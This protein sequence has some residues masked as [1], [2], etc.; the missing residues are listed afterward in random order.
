VIFPL[1]AKRVNPFLSRVNANGV[2]SRNSLEVIFRF[3][4]YLPFLAESPLR[5]RAP[6]RPYVVNNPQF[7]G[8]VWTRDLPTPPWSRN[9]RSD[10]L[11]GSL[12]FW[13]I[14][15]SVSAAEFEEAHFGLFDGQPVPGE[16]MPTLHFRL[17]PVFA[18]AGLCAPSETVDINFSPACL[19][20]TF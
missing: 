18:L 5:R 4:I 20:N 1:G 16:T 2:R 19:F 10:S 9:C 15:L 7:K 6:G 17:S 12:R 13:R 3:L 11:E 8:T 14:L